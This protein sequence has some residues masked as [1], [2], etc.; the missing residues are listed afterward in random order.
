MRLGIVG[1][2]IHSNDE[3][4]WDNLPFLLCEGF[5]CNQL[6]HGTFFSLG[7]MVNIYTVSIELR[8]VGPL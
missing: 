6:T 3:Q 4:C 8:S 2:N 5:K 7:Y 1:V